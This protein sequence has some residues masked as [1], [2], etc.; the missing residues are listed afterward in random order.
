MAQARMIEGWETEDEGWIESGHRLAS[1]WRRPERTVF[2]LDR[3]F[4][5]LTSRAITAQARAGLADIRDQRKR[6]R[7]TRFLDRFEQVAAR[8]LRP[9]D[10]VPAMV[11][12]CGDDGAFLVEWIFPN[13]RLGF[14]FEEN[15][16]ESGWYFV[17]KTTNASGFLVDADIQ[18]LAKWTLQDR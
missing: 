9:H 11:S 4:Q 16:N 14:A 7:I 1:A 12:V 13:R 10:E 17:S 5:T 6:E 15:D 18:M 3:L 2:N 8:H